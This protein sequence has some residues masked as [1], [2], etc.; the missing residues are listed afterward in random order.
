MPFKYTVGY[1]KHIQ[2]PSSRFINILTIELGKIFEVG[3]VEIIAL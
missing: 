3:I 2:C 1:H